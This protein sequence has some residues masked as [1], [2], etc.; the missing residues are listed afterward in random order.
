V[1]EA[2]EFR[3]VR[4]AVQPPAA[5]LLDPAQQRIVAHDKGVL[6]VLAGPGTGKTTTL[7]ESVVD[8]VANRGVAVDDVLLLTFSR[9]AAGELRDRVTARLQRTI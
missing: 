3:L 2:T 4:A 9:L 7:V 5:P 1:S 8:R 6:R